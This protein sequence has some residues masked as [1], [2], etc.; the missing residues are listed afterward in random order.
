MFIPDMPNVPPQD[1][2][3][4]IAQANQAQSS[5]A[6]TVRTVGI[7]YGI[8]N[9]V[10][11]SPTGGNVVDPREEAHNYLFNYEKKNVANTVPTTVTILQQPAHGILRLI[12]QADIGTILPGSGGTVDPA[13]PGYIYLPEKGYIGQ[14]KAVV[15]VEIGG[16]KVKEIFY[17]HDM[18]ERTSPCNGGDGIYSTWK[19][20]STLDANGTS[21]LTSVD[22]LPSLATATTPVTNAATLASVLGTSLASTLDAN[23]TGVT[24]N[25]ANLPNAAIGQTVGTN[26]TLDT[27]AAGYGWYIAPNPATKTDCISGR[28]PNPS[29]NTD[30]GDKAAG[31][32]YVKR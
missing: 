15:L 2:P 19:I 21:T 30:A 5:T 1:V 3:V 6:L 22:Y 28:R 25:I 17:F 26:I 13:N 8:P 7:C 29:I 32:G 23:T 9:G 16:V 24:L 11:T 12:T 27:N 14:D 10:D 18:D 20:S 31:A 4:M